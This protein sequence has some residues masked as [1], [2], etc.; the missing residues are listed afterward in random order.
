MEVIVF[1]ISQLYLRDSLL[2]IITDSKM[3]K[4]QLATI[5]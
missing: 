5:S 1:I 4:N 3:R 2:W